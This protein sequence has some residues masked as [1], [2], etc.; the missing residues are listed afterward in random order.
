MDTYKLKFTL[1]EQDIKNCRRELKEIY[2]ALLEVYGYQGWWPL[3]NEKTSKIEYHPG[4]YSY[5]KNDSQRFE[6]CQDA[7]LTQNTSWKNVEKALENLK[8]YN[9]L[10]K[11]KLKL[12]EIKKLAEIIKS[13]G[14][15]NQK[16]KKIKEFIKFLD[17]KKEINRNNL[18][19]IWGIGNE[20]ADSILLYAHKNPV[21]VI[22][23]YTKR[24]FSRLGFCKESINYDEL[25]KLFHKNLEK[26]HKLFNEYHA[27]IVEHAK[28]FCKKKPLCDNCPIKTHCKYFTETI[29]KQ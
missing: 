11:E 27:L 5:P 20:T 3:F 6:I 12:I 25:Q 19:A 16:A 15:N 28:R 22:D 24:I 18:L 2:K 17:S 4:D 29:I 7:I 9:L 13:S 26:N 23:S 1:L 8:K 10:N 21:F 14:Y